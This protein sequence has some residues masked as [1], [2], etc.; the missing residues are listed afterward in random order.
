MRSS[1]KILM[2]VIII[3]VVLAIAGTVLGYL[4]I[5]T[6]FLKSNKEL[7]GKYIMQDIQKIQEMTQS[8]TYQTYKNIKNQNM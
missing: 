8:N 6:D 3:I 1:R 7:F 5:K 2:I 4:Y